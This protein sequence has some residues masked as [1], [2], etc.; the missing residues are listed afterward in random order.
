[1]RNGYADRKGQYVELET[2]PGLQQKFFWRLVKNGITTTTQASAYLSVTEGGTCME[3]DKDSE[4]STS[5]GSAGTSWL[6]RTLHSLT[7]TRHSSA[8]S[9]ASSDGSGELPSPPSSRGSGPFV[10]KPRFGSLS[11]LLSGKSGKQEEVHG[12][13]AQFKLYPNAVAASHAEAAKPAS[14][15]ADDHRAESNGSGTARNSLQSSEHST[16]TPEELEH[17]ISTVEKEL[18]QARRNHLLD[19]HTANTHRDTLQ[20]LRVSGSAGGMAEAE[21]VHGVLASILS[22][23]KAFSKGAQQADGSYQT[24]ISLRNGQQVTVQAEYCSMDQTSMGADCACVTIAFKVACWCDL[25]PT[26]HLDA[27]TLEQLLLEGGK[28]WKQLSQ[29]PDVREEFPSGMLDFE[30]VMAEY[31]SECGE[32]LEINCQISAA[33]LMS[34]KTTFAEGMGNRTV[35][36]YLLTCCNHCVAVRVAA[37]GSVQLANS[38]GRCLAQTCKLGHVITCKSMAEFVEL[39][40]GMNQPEGEDACVQ[41]EIHQISHSHRGK[42]DFIMLT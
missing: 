26:R 1:M 33:G 12:G 24:V 42:G 15:D 22:D 21:V 9:K 2:T 6:S 32:V 28:Q 7:S 40:V 3:E 11:R 25:Y 4:C 17:A 27:H 31:A 38:L 8:S 29:R 36:V 19:T 20:Q 13:D 16:S 37:D 30:S 34:S 41:V 18:L 14:Q 10:K 5:T 35:G 23:I 39:Y